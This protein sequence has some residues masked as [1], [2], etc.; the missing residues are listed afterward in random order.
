MTK[1]ITDDPA[2]IFLML[3][4]P[5]DY[6]TFRVYDYIYDFC[7]KFAVTYTG[8][9]VNKDNDTVKITFPSEEERFKFAL[10]L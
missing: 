2:E 7:Q 10:C 1:Q 9:Y 3:G 8:V 5:E 4:L 6:T